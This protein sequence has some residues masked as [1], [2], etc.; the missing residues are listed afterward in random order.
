MKRRSLFRGEGKFAYRLLAYQLFVFRRVGG[1]GEWRRFGRFFRERPSL[2]RRCRRLGD[3]GGGE[4]TNRVVGGLAKERACANQCFAKSLWGL[5]QRLLSTA[6]RA[7]RR[8]N[9]K[10][11]FPQQLGHARVDVLGQGIP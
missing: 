1:D 6:S 2:V 5:G 7:R 10:Q 9:C 11:G 4:R 8:Q 3:A